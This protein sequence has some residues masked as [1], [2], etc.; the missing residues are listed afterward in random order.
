L[1]RAWSDQQAATRVILYQQGKDVAVAGALAWLDDDHLLVW[2]DDHLGALD[3]T[4]E[5][6]VFSDYVSAQAGT[7]D[8]AALV[9]MPGS[10]TKAERAGPHIRFVDR[11]LHVRDTPAPAGYRDCFS[12]TWHPDGRRLAV[13]C[14]HDT[15]DQTGTDAFQ[16]DPDIGR[17]SPLRTPGLHP[18]TVRWLPDNHGLLIETAGACS[19]PTGVW[20]LP[21]H[22]PPRELQGRGN[23]PVTST[24]PSPDGT[25]VIAESPPCSPA[26]AIVVVQLDGTSSEPVGAGRRPLWSPAP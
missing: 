2:R 13:V 8:R 21:P 16:V 18:R 12:P 23:E 6:P 25:R 7:R 24:D 15:D 9:V 11:A 20:R 14:Q 26:P 19:I 3:V 4:V 1:F 22:G 5:G 10:P 17:W